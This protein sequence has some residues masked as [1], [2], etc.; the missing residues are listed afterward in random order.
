MRMIQAFAVQDTVAGCDRIEASGRDDFERGHPGMALE[1]V[2][3]R[4]RFS[5]E[6]KGIDRDWIPV[7]ATRATQAALSFLDAAA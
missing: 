4:A 3:C 5:K 7:A 6:D 1:D 2:R